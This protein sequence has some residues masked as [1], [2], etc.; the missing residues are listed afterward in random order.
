METIKSKRILHS[1]IK[2]ILQNSPEDNLDF[3]Q[4]LSYC[5][6]MGQPIFKISVDKIQEDFFVDDKGQK[7]VKA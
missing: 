6:G 1:K 4:I 7:W 5:E 2:K 3:P